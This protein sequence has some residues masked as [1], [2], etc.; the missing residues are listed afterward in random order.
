MVRGMKSEVLVGASSSPKSPPRPRSE[1]PHRAAVSREEAANVLETEVAEG[2][3]RADAVSAILAVARLSRATPPPRGTK[4][5]ERE[6]EVLALVARGLSNKEVARTLGISART[7]QTQTIRVS[8]KL[9]VRTRAEA[10][11]R[12][13]ELG[14]LGADARAHP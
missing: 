12:G 3:L 7:V 13:A 4:L 1:R 10:A 9:G 14:L 2:R 11:L 5:S 6:R 8:D